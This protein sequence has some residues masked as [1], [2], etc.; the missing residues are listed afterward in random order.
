MN[1][2]FKSK[3]NIATQSYVACSELTRNAGKTTLLAAPMFISTGL[4]PPAYAAD[5]TL[6]NNSYYVSWSTAN[7]C[8]NVPVNNN[9]QLINPPNID[10]WYII[11]GPELR[12]TL[13]VGDANATIQGSST[14][15]LIGNRQS[16]GINGAKISAN[17]ITANLTAGKQAFLFRTSH[18]LDITAKD[19]KANLTVGGESTS[20]AF[21]IYH[22]AILVGSD[23]L[24]ANQTSENNPNANG[25][26]TTLTLNN[27]TLESKAYNSTKN[28]VNIG[29]RANQAGNGSSGKIIIKDKLNLLLTGSNMQGIYASGAKANAVG[30]KA[31]STIELNHTDINLKREG[32]DHSDPSQT[33]SAIKVGLAYSY[34]AGEGQVHSKGTLNIISD[35]IGTTGIKLFHSN[36]LFKADYDNSRTRISVLGPAIQISGKDGSLSLIHI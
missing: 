17:N 27:L 7:L 16:L 29:L 35:Q 13:R 10:P 31:V 9:F 11:T 21:N 14:A 32:I 18:G 6:T 25:T 2:I 23:Q 4:I 34:A 28:L 8:D 12:T 36:S 30:E 26:F 5:C 22:T 20:S 3:W 24:T 33:N 15:T 19:V 1:R